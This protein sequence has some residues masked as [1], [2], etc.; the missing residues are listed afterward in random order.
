MCVCLCA[1]VRRPR[2]RLPGRRVC[3]PLWI[4]RPDALNSPLLFDVL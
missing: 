4:R 1:N 3:A 2:R